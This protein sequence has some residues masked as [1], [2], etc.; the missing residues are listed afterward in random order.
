MWF[1]HT[2]VG[3]WAPVSLIKLKS[4]MNPDLR[5]V[6]HPVNR[7]LMRGLWMV[8]VTTCAGRSVTPRRAMSGAW[9]SRNS[10]QTLTLSSSAWDPSASN[11]GRSDI[12]THFTTV[13]SIRQFTHVYFDE[14]FY[15][16]HFQERH[17]ISPVMRNNG[18]PWITAVKN[19][20]QCN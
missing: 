18:F 7:I 15:L 5:G 12:E 8:T 4:L 14:S 13:W 6:V 9:T 10:H 2:A 17:G 1:D 19:Y 20:L 16:V 3:R 11:R